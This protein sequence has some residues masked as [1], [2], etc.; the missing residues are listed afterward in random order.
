M[1]YGKSGGDS[2]EIRVS[3]LDSGNG[4]EEILKKLNFLPFE[5]GADGRQ[6]VKCDNQTCWYM[7][8][9]H[10]L[11]IVCIQVE[12]NREKEVVQLVAKIERLIEEGRSTRSKAGAGIVFGEDDSLEDAKRLIIQLF[13][14]KQSIE[15]E[16]S[17]AVYELKKTRII[18][19]CRQIGDIRKRLERC[20]K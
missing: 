5:E 14:E 3:W 15:K 19:G 2:M 4:P 9:Q 20:F 12:K 11:H 6:V 1:K 13:K 18:V 17:Q 7:K 8:G 10:W 16:I